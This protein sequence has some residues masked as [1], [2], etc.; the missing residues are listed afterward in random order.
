MSSPDL[1]FRLLA[2]TPPTGAVDGAVVEA[3][4][5]G[6]ADGAGIAV[7]L[8]EPGLGPAAILAPD[9]RL[10]ALRRACDRAGIRVLLG[11][12]PQHVDAGARQMNTCGLAGLQ[13]RGD[14]T[15]E[16]LTFARERLADGILG[17]SCHD[18]PQL[19]H[20]LCD[21]TCF[22]PVFEP[23]TQQAGA[24]KRPAGP[25]ALARWCDGPGARIFAVGGVGPKT[26]QTCVEAGAFGLAG[27]GSFFG[28]PAR[29]TQDVAA[30]C[31]ALERARRSHAKKET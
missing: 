12:D 15:L 13:L 2:I 22:G 10:A 23:R 18:D 14:P 26:A 21:Y 27:I 17:R 6:G 3:W 9:G 1:P 11:C 8:R 19:G 31:A 29:V 7:L 5:S 24:R 25:E 20:D 30:L 4:R 28:D 16:E